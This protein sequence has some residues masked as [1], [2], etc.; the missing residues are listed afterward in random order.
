MTKQLPHHPDGSSSSNIMGVVPQKFHVNI[1]YSSVSDPQPC[2]FFSYWVI[3]RCVKIKVIYLISQGVSSNSLGFQ[4][5]HL[6]L[7]L[8]LISSKIPCL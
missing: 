7:L 3:L 1:S 5:C 6:K 8:L 4:S 2:S